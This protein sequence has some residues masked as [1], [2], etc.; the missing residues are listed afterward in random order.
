MGKESY[1][2]RFF[3]RKTP[4]YYHAFYYGGTSLILYPIPIYFTLL[5][6]RVFAKDPKKVS[7]ADSDEKALRDTPPPFPADILLDRPF[8]CS[9][10]AWNLFYK[11]AR[12]CNIT[13]SINAP[14]PEQLDPERFREALSS[15]DNRLILELIRDTPEALHE[16]EIRDKLIKC[17]K[18]ARIT[19]ENKLLLQDYLLPNRKKKIFSPERYMLAMEI[20]NR[21][22]SHLSK[23]CNDF[24]RDG[25]AEDYDTLQR[26][27]QEAGEDRICALSINDLKTLI[28]TPAKYSKQEVQ[29]AA[30]ISQ[31]TAKRRSIPQMDK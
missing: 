19:Q 4:L 28:H 27:A 16:K 3:A 11:Y 7:K 25:I 22:S 12:I 17:L 14:Y 23:I 18:T 2:F 21:L 29:K 5:E 10:E 24:L 8:I 30:N 20:T 1:Q 6:R 13:E 26:W 15:S 9:S 31:K